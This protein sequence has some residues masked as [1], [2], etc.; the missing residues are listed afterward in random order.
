MGKVVP[1][2]LTEVLPGDTFDHSANVLIRM[3]PLAAPVM[4]PV[5]VRLHHF[6]VPN[7]LVWEMA[8]GTGSWED[9]ITSGPDGNDSQTVPTVN[10][11]GA[12][13]GGILDHYGI[14]QANNMEVNALPL[15]GYNL[16]YNEWFRDEDLKTERAWNTLTT[17]SCAWEKDYFT[18]AR[19]WPQK[20]DSVTL[21]VAGT[22][23]VLGI[24]VGDTESFAS[25]ATPLRETGGTE[26]GTGTK[27]VSTS[28]DVWV[29][30]DS[31]TPGYPAIYADLKQAEAVSINEFRRA[32]AL[33]RYAEARSRYGSRYTEYLR[34]LGIRSSDARL[35][36]PE[37][38]GGGKA[39]VSISEVL[40]T[41]PEA[42]TPPAR[43]YGVGDMYGHGVA[44]MRSNRYRKFFEEHGYVHTLMSVRPKSIYRD[45]IH[46]TFLRRTRDEFWQR[47]LQFIGQQ[48]VWE[49]E[50]FRRSPSLA[51]NTWGYQDRYSEYR[52]N[53]SQ[54]S[55]DFRDTLNYWHLAREFTDTPALNAAFVDCNPSKRIFNEQT[56]DSLWVMVQHRQ[57]AR[58]LVSRSAAG[59]IL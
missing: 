58:R 2:G 45:G 22:A 30:E 28:G 41:G 29:E 50:V 7:R 10:T 57:V 37:L 15:A 17:G 56:Q 19:P 3:S 32:F 42:T 33:Q 5:T 6:F 16:I 38:I 26:Y 48:E 40:Q 53:P 34:Y 51:Y 21:P 59:K 18:A 47:E 27:T 49:G 43:D 54:I 20:G 14:P 8:G 9:F 1:V 39:R 23:P 13:K 24:G 31:Q 55:G 35:Q 4:H 36:R 44:A 12:E 11:T 52:N 25:N 46:R